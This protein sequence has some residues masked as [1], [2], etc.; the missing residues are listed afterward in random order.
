VS[1]IKKKSVGIYFSFLMGI[2]INFRIKR[3]NLQSQI[4][5]RF[6]T[7]EN[8]IQMNRQFSKTHNYLI[9]HIICFKIKNPPTLHSTSKIQPTTSPTFVF[10]V[11]ASVRKKWGYERKLLRVVSGVVHSVF[12]FS[13]YYCTQKV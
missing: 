5:V 9:E 6:S 12:L 10:S 13:F 8:Q 3:F 2:I 11:S 4:H 1:K 7:L